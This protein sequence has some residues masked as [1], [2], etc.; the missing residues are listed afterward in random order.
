LLLC[1]F[2]RV[3]FQSKIK[4]ARQTEA[5]SMVCRADVSTEEWK[6]PSQYFTPMAK[7]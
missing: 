3:C 2:R 1:R 7:G 4:T 6:A 5:D